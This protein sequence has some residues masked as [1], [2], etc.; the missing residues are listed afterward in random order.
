MRNQGVRPRVWFGEKWLTEGL[1]ELFDENV[2]YYPSLLPI[3]DDEDPQHP[4]DGRD[5][6]GDRRDDTTGTP[7]GPPGPLTEPVGSADPAPA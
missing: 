3:C 6:I 1:F 2:R 4:R 5:D 7:S